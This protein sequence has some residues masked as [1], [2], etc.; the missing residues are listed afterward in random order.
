MLV[1]EVATPENRHLIPSSSW[2]PE[3]ISIN[4]NGTSVE[5]GSTEGLSQIEALAFSGDFIF[6]IFLVILVSAGLIMIYL[7]GLASSIPGLSSYMKRNVEDSSSEK[8]LPGGYVY[9][10]WRRELRL[11]YLKFL[12]RLRDMGVHI[13]S[14]YTAY[15]VAEEASKADVMY[16]SELAKLYNFGMFSPR[17]DE[18]ILEGFKRFMDDEG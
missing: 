5:Q 14:G 16:A 17:S 7:Y 9:T 2:L 6:L 11:L 1:L 13:M 8:F 15:E 12:K 10:G 4:V 3:N 18:S